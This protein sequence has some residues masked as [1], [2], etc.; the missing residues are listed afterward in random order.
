MGL[1]LIQEHKHEAALF[2]IPV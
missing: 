2:C 1:L